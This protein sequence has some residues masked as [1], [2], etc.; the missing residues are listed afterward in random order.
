MIEASNLANTD[1]L[2]EMVGLSV[3]IPQAYKGPRK[4]FYRAIKAKQKKPER[5]K[6]VIMLARTRAKAE[7]LADITQTTR[8]F[9]WRCMLQA[10]KIGEFWRS[11][12]SYVHYMPC[13]HCQVNNSLEHT[14]IE[15]SAPGKEILWG[16][17]QKLWELKGYQWPEISLGRILACRFAEV[18]DAKW[19]ERPWG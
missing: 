15:C 2:E 11:I 1:E 9:L 7:E 3:E 18:E 4:S 13:Y 17:A 14:L 12:P 5:Q 6:T 10:Y 16:L 19:E 8:D